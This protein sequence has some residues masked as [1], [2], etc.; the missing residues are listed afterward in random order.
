VAVDDS[1]VFPGLPDKKLSPGAAAM[2]SAGG[3]LDERT[4]SVVLLE[5]MARGRIHL[6]DR[7]WTEQRGTDLQLV[8]SD[9]FDPLTYDPDLSPEGTN[10]LAA[11]GA[12]AGDDGYLTADS[13]TPTRGPWDHQGQTPLRTTI[14]ALEPAAFAATIDRTGL[15]AHAPSEAPKTAAQTTTGAWTK[16]ELEGFRNLLATA[17]AG[18]T[19]LSEG[20]LPAGPVG[21]EE[22]E[23]LLIWSV[24]LGLDKEA[25]AELARS[26]GGLYADWTPTWCRDTAPV[27]GLDARGAALEATAHLADEMLG[28]PSPLAPTLGERV[29]E[30]ELDRHSLL[31]PYRRG[32]GDVVVDHLEEDKSGK[33]DW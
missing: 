29:I 7:Y 31:R 6:R 28:G 4:L 23:R 2:L 9:T 17:Y 33:L 1:V 18:K 24:A 19:V 15:V 30:G 22:H 16:A 21:L 20:E 13:R 26:D 27:H 10:L 14:A 32:L 11:L 25:C 8:T 12:L 5:L 3:Q